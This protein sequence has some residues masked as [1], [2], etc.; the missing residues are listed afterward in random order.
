M[1]RAN[2]LAKRHKQ[3][4]FIH[5]AMVKSS[6]SILEKLASALQ[7]DLDAKALFFPIGHWERMLPIAKLLE[8][9]FRMKG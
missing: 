6:L 4:C 7:K 8:S 3:K 9:V 5:Q 2:C 1:A